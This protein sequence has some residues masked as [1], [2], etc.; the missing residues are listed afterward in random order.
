MAHVTASETSPTTRGGIKDETLRYLLNPTQCDEVKSTH[1]SPARAFEVDQTQTQNSPRSFDFGINSQPVNN[2]QRDFSNMSDIPGVGVPEDVGNQNTNILSPVV[3]NDRVQT[4][5]KESP[6]KTPGERRP[7]KYELLA[8]L[9]RLRSRGFSVRS[10]LTAE[11]PEETI[12]AE[13]D[14]IK[15]E[16]ALNQSVRMYRRFLV[17]F[18]TFTEWGN[19]RFDPIG[20]ELDGWTENTMINIDDYDSIFERMFESHKGKFKMSPMMELMFTMAGSAFMFHMTKSRFKA[21][22]EVGDATGVPTVVPAPVP[23]AGPAESGTPFVGSLMSNMARA[24][25]IPS[26]PATGPSAP[27]APTAQQPMQAAAPAM[28]AMPIIP[29]TTE[30]QS[31]QEVPAG[32]QMPPEMINMAAG[33]LNNP[34]IM[35]MMGSMLGGMGRMN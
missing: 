11:T 6:H 3:A 1:V 32:M 20:L 5:P 29:E 35:N 12:Y 10:D 22:G 18:V 26:M 33:M 30:P 4:P 13:W 23:K 21:S 24:M 15:E 19:N 28:P 9:S 34:Q 27:S 2:V 25:S 16:V 31:V 7:S 14:K 17:A 8:K